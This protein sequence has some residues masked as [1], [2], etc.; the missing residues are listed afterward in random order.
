MINELKL[1]SGQNMKVYRSAERYQQVLQE[2]IVAL[3][4]LVTNKK[5]LSIPDMGHL[6]ASAFKVV[7][8]TTCPWK[9]LGARINVVHLSPF[10]SF[11]IGLTPDFWFVH[12]QIFL[13]SGFPMPLPDHMWCYHCLNNPKHGSW[14]IWLGWKSSDLLAIE[15]SSSGVEVVDLSAT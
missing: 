1:N 7:F 12:L 8:I 13:Q 3:K 2:L 5:W 10:Y 14:L 6:V 9:P 11:I 15:N 4:K